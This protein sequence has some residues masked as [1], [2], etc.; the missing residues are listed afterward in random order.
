MIQIIS[1]FYSNKDVTDIVRSKLINDKLSI[2]ASNNLFGD[3]TPNVF[4]YLT[5]KYKEDDIFKE[6]VIK[7]NDICILPVVDKP[8]KTYNNT[9]KIKFIIPVPDVSYYLWQVLVQIN[10]FRKM[11]Y[12]IDAHYPVCCFYSNQ[13]NI[14]KKLLSSDNIKSKF[15]PYDDDRVDRTYT[16]SM[17]PWL[18]SKYFQQFPE[19]K[20]NIYIYLDPDVIFFKH[21]NWNDYADDDIWYESDTCSY[22]DSRYIKSKSDDLFIEMCNIV[23]ISPQLVISN[24]LNCGGA[25]YITKNN[26]Y[27]Y[28]KEVELTS[29]PLYKHM[30]ATA[31]KYKKD[32]QIYPI[33]AWTSEMWTTN[34]VLWKNGIKTK[35]IDELNF[36]WANHHI[37]DLRYSIYH[38]A[39]VTD[40]NGSHFSKT[41]YQKSPFMQE[42]KGSVDSISYK[43]IEEIKSTEINFPELVKIFE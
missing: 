16:A 21:I 33:Q 42:L 20:D 23:G 34:W 18:M 4:K 8:I 37:R 15:H 27:E 6:L 9:K 14:L 11:G 30:V 32:G 35:C 24:D 3:P 19:E 39:G 28:W 5:I 22:L 38:N 10:N 12:E 17:K 25:Q 2:V 29:V 7:E 43:Y 13:S 40:N 41:A 31:E 1:A 26:T 36:H